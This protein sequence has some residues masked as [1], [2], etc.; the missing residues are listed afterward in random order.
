MRTITRSSLDESPELFRELADVLHAGGLVCFPVGRHYIIAASLL[1]EDAVM[2]LVQTKRRSR[3]APSL[4]FV[5]DRDTVGH[6][7]SDIP[8]RAVPLMD[9]CWPGPLTILFQPGEGL[10]RK[11]S[12][13]LVARK[14]DRLGI[15][16]T[17]EPMA[18]QLV[19]TFGGPLLISSANLSKKVGSASLAQVR[20]NFARTVDVMVDAGD[21]GTS[22][23]STVVDPLSTDRPVVREG[24]VPTDQVLALLD[25]TP[26]EA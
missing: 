10:P 18:R 2:R 17:Q 15:R 21:V 24:A 19:E 14:T 7:V 3:R 11:V 26:A 12:K 23:P 9:A 6:L 5:P 1:D 13:T 8:E 25:S 16:M 20:K 4:V 22:A